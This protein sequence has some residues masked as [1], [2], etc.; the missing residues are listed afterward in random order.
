MPTNVSQRIPNV[1][2]FANSSD[3]NFKQRRLNPLPTDW[4]RIQIYERSVEAL[5]LNIGKKVR[6]KC[7]SISGILVFRSVGLCFSILV[8]S[9]PR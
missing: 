6:F 3:L 8:V 1:R 9:I 2:T 5:R 7:V 4:H